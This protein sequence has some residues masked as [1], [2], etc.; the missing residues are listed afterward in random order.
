MAAVEPNKN[1]E[2]GR[3]TRARLVAVATEL[4]AERGFDKT[5]VELVLERAA[6]SKGSLY[7]H[8]ANKEALFEAVLDTVEAGVA[9]ATVNAARGHEDPIE[10]L[11]AACKGWLRLARDPVVRQ[12]VL[13][14]A[15]AIM[16]WQK[17]REI[18]ERHAFGILKRA[19]DATAAPE[20]SGLGS[21]VIAHILLASIIE[22]AMLI[23]RAERPRKA[24]TDGDAALDRLL[25]GLFAR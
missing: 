24:L 8:F 10:A 25:A 11:R 13:I 3:S 23:A 1:V 18:D 14:D 21:D 5:S 15:P 16:G 19:I 2:R 6:V 22:I 17:W 12:V 9:T 7:H 4:F 20:T